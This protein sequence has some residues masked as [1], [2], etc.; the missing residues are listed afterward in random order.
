MTNYFNRPF[1]IYSCWYYY[2]DTFVL[3]MGDMVGDSWPK[4]FLFCHHIPC[5]FVLPY[6]AWT[7]Y[8]PSW[9]IGN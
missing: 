3:I 8:V 6:I 2:F 5:L 4:F 9:M 7:P 1:F